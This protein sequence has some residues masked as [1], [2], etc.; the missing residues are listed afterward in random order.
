MTKTSWGLPPPSVFEND[1]P[2]A[3]T[4]VV[5][6]NIDTVDED[7]IYFNINVYQSFRT[8]SQQWPWIFASVAAMFNYNA[9][10][11]M[12]RLEYLHQVIDTLV[13]LRMPEVLRFKAPNDLDN[14]NIWELCD[15][16]EW[17]GI[18]GDIISF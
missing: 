11:W 4:G 18:F 10:L 16:G 12:K 5:Q 15:F 17:T 6:F 13:Y 14:G 9:L 3:K 2:G 7:R 1:K 8:Q